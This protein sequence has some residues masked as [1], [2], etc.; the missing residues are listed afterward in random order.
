MLSYPDFKEKTVVTVFATQGQK[1]SFLNDNLIVKDND[2]EVVL[3]TSCHRMLALW[4]V[5]N[6]TFTTGLLER[7]KKFGFPIV[8][9]SQNL[10]LIGAWNAPT[11]GNFLLRKKQYSY[12][13][14]NIAKHLVYNK[15]INQ[16]ELLKSIR[17]KSIA[18]KDAIENIKG[19]SLQI[20]GMNDLTS[21]LGLEGVSAK[22]YFNVWY[23][24]L[25]W[26]GRKPRTKHDPLN[27]LLDMGYTYLFYYIENMLHLYG[28]DVYKG[29][30]HTN[31]YKRKSLVC[32][33]QEPFRCIVD[34]AVKKA[35]ALGQVNESDFDFQKGQYSLK[36][37]K[38]K[39]Y[40]RLLLAAIIDYKSDLFLYC[41]QYYRAFIQEKEISDFPVFNIGNPKE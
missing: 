40:T 22:V 2:D 28:F 25:D 12:D 36:Y 11:E 1:F 16:L 18:C 17:Q 8:H 31:F 41:Q 4:I 10:K 29:V 21:L 20:S 35:Y 5:G 3:Q 26:K 24:N 23:E 32:D 37:S 33:L 30:Y 34:K 14:L 38:S 15:I 6:G 19:Y 39:Y 27:V 7:S 13:S 9:M